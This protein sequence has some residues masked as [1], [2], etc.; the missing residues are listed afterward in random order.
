MFSGQRNVVT[1]Q[2]PHS[3]ILMRWGGGGTNRGSYFIAKKIQ[4][5]EFIYPK[6]T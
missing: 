4:T 6:N 5:S 3:D 2:G 1:A